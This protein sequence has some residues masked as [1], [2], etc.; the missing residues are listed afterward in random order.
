VRTDEKAGGVIV[1]DVFAKLN[2]KAQAEIVVLDAPASFEAEIGKLQGVSV[3]RSLPK[4][5]RVA[6]ALAFVTKLSEVESIAKAIVKLAE[7]DPIIWFAYP[8]GS[9]RRYKCEFNRETGW[10]AL[11]AAGFE[12]VRMIAIDEDWSAVR[13][14]RAEF[15]KTLI[16]DPVH[17]MSAVGRRRAAKK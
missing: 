11:G 10:A 6:F 14:R 15:I 9:S 1:A 8:K 12:G 7:G 17:T 5:G 3:M 2:L 4:R 13:F 16:R